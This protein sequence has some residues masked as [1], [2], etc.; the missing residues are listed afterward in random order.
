MLNSLDTLR[1][2]VHY[3]QRDLE[4]DATSAR[5]SR[6]ARPRRRVRSPWLTRRDAAVLRANVAAL[7]ARTA[8]ADHRPIETTPVAGR[9][10]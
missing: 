7:V 4:A 10:K 2:Q 1:A 9:R 8:P 6:A 3:H 5:L